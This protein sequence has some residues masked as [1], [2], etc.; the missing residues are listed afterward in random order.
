MQWNWNRWPW[1]RDPVLSLRARIDS[2]VGPTL[3]HQTLS[4]IRY[5]QSVGVPLVIERSEN[6]V[7]LSLEEVR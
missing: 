2:R 1:T 4:A 7:Y 6:R 3:F 5:Y